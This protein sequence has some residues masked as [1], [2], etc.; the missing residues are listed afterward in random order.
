MITIT[1]PEWVD[2]WI[3]AVCIVYLI[4]RAID[5]YYW[6]LKIKYLDMKRKYKAE[7]GVDYE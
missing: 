2:Y 5:V 6:Y 1:M 4:S 3:L 7:F